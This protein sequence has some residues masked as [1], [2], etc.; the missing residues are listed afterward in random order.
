MA[1]L[2]RCALAAG[3]L[4]DAER[5]LRQ[6]RHVDPEAPRVIDLERRLAAAARRS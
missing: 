2:G 5:W 1:A 6:A 3:Q 4:R